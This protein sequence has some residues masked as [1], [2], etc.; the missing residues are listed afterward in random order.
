[1]PPALL[2]LVIGAVGLRARPEQSSWSALGGGLG[3]LVVPPVVQVLDA[4]DDLV[5]LVAVV[6]VGCALASVGRYARLQAPL[7]WGVG[8]LALV[9]LTQHDEVTGVLPRWLLL[10]G[11][12]ALL[13]WLSISY[14]R[15]L[16][17]LTAVREG[18]AAMR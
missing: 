2:I 8:A 3:L 16:R 13:L 17:R 15:Q 5:R 11:G 10:A 12:G 1:M 18:L 14:E 9:A 6:V 7:V 4:P